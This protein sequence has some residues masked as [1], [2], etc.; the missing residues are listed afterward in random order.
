MKRE[1]IDVFV[2]GCI[3]FVLDFVPQTCFDELMSKDKKNTFFKYYILCLTKEK[4]YIQASNHIYNFGWT[5][6]LKVITIIFI[7]SKS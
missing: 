4:T 3:S 2:L 1:P 5:M 6:L 7:H